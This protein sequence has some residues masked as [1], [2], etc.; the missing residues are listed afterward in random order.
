VHVLQRIHRW[1][2]PGGRVLDIHPEPEAASVEVAAHG[3]L[4]RIGPFDRLAI[5]DKITA[6][7][8]ALAELVDDGLYDRER[9]I[10][11][12]LLYHFDSVEAW[13]A[14]RAD[15]GSSTVVPPELQE[16]ASEVLAETAGE[17]LIR[18][19]MRATRYRR[20]AAPPRK[21]KASQQRDLH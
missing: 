11:F 8:T 5:Y 3:S 16:R 21:P 15:R 9:S 14:Y 12:E 6:A 13:L 17:L 4:T 19:Q 18:E 20:R 1:L 7:R 10:S 2:R